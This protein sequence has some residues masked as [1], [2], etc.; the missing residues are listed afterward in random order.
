[1]KAWQK[2]AQDARTITV[3][4]I[5]NPA[6]GPGAKRDPTYVNVVSD[7]RKAGGKVLGYISTQYARRDISL[8]ERDLR[9]YL[10]F[11]EVDGVFLDE[12]SGSKDALPYYEKIHRLI[13]ELKPSFRI[14][15]NPGQPS[16]DEQ[17]MRT[18]DCLVIFEG[19][20]REY[21][22]FNPH[23]SAP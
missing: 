10:A 20:A 1:L 4:V 21:A 15:G 22:R 5:L 14:V 9:T 7:F 18:V 23:V 13:K 11:Y 8:I 19:S 2:L 17:Y 3:E 12:M 16:V 6:S